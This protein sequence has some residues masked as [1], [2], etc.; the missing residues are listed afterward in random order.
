M[1]DKSMDSVFSNCT[2][3]ELEFEA[4]FDN[5][6]SIIE[7]VA[8][9]DEAGNSLIGEDFDWEAFDA[10]GEADDMVGEKPD[11]DYPNDE[12][13]SN[14]EDSKDR[15]VE[16]GGEVGDGKEVSGKEK[17]A[18]SQAYD[19]TKEV[20]DSIGLNDKQQTSLE[21][22]DLLDL[23]EGA[24]DADSNVGGPKPSDD[25][26]TM[27]NIKDTEAEKLVCPAC[28]K[29]PCECGAKNEGAMLDTILDFLNEEDCI[30]DKCDTAE[31]EGKVNHDTSDVEGKSQEVIG[32]AIDGNTKEDPIA[33]DIDDAEARDGKADPVSD[34]EGKDVH[35]VGAALEDTDITSDLLELIESS[36]EF[37]EACNKEGCNKE[38]A[39]TDAQE[40]N[41]PDESEDEGCCKEDASEGPLEDDDVAEREGE[42]SDAAV[43]TESYELEAEMFELLE[44]EDPIADD[45]DDAEARDG[46]A[47]PVSDTE[48]K[49]QKVI[50]AALEANDFLDDVID[51]ADPEKPLIDMDFDFLLGDET[52]QDL[53]SDEDIKVAKEAAAEDAMSDDQE[54]EAIESID[55]ESEEGEADI[56]SGYDDDELIDAV[57]NGD[58][59]DL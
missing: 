8:G 11:F 25:M 4:M 3:K 43:E 22:A 36:E 6:D 52:V 29:N 1:S 47:D 7:A 18:E 55:A 44:Q 59:E 46:K 40:D 33:D 28:G 20:D 10:L 5:D 2:E 56:E 58:I 15:K 42:T 26:G 19:D 9:V 14:F 21:A 31:R 30:D 51:E 35:A 24:E 13:G 27:D 17:S 39:E 53:V 57:I 16:V 49:D 54:D 12:V 38:E 41:T 32:Q 37:E 34:T 48:G 50:G 23:I 45:I